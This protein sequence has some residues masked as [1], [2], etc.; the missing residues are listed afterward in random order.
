MLKKK[1]NF[2]LA[3]M[4]G[5]AFLVAVAITGCNGSDSKDA[6]TDSTNTKKMDEV[7]PIA[8]DSTST[9]GDTAKIKPVVPGN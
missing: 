6:K 3:S 9:K 7:K 5:F 1:L 4:L 2:T 8:P